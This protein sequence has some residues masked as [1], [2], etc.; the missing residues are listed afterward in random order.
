MSFIYI[1][2]INTD[3]GTVIKVGHGKTEPSVRMREYV[4]QYRL[5]GD[6]TSLSYKKVDN[7]KRAEEYIHKSLI[8]NGYSNIRDNKFGPQELFQ[9][10]PN[11]SYRQAKELFNRLAN[12]WNEIHS[13]KR[14]KASELVGG[15]TKKTQQLTSQDNFLKRITLKKTFLYF[16]KLV[17]LILIIY[18]TTLF[19]KS[20]Y[21]MHGK[22]GAILIGC[23]VV[24]LI[25]KI[26]KKIYLWKYI[27]SKVT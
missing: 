22:E 18:P 15:S 9:A 12:E 25:Y 1:Y 14:Y 13:Y 21:E 26:G 6:F 4:K 10:P 2:K 7:S 16:H 27:F 20:H 17:V 23:L 3:V 11:V 5:D 19:L 24:L 8:L